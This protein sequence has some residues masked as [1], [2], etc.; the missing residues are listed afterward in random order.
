MEYPYRFSLWGIE[1]QVLPW[2]VTFFYLFRLYLVFSSFLPSLLNRLNHPSI[3]YRM[4]VLELI[5]RLFQ[6]DW[7]LIWI[8][9]FAISFSLLPIKIGSLFLGD[10]TF[11]CRNKKASCMI[12]D[13]M[14]H[15]NGRIELVLFIEGKTIRPSQKRDIV[16]KPWWG[17]I[18]LKKASLNLSIIMNFPVAWCLWACH[19]I[20]ISKKIKYVLSLRNYL[21][22]WPGFSLWPSTS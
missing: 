4:Q 11:C 14:S 21:Q 17:G 20:T 8:Y 12:L 5:W 1:G 2:S 13:K 15:T 7:Y 3:T 18:T 10:M 19:R 9:P 16:L 22:I 6:S